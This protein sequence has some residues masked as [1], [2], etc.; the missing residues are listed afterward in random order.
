MR[1]NRILVWNIRGINSQ[2]KWDALRSKINE[3]ACHIICLQ[4]TKREQFDFFYLKN[5][6]PRNFDGFFYSPSI[7]ASGGLLTI[8]NSRM[9]SA[10][11][12]QS[13]SYAITAKFTSVLDNK[14]F[15]LTNIY[16]PSNHSENFA[17]VTWLLNLDITTFDEWLLAGDF[18]LYSS[19]DDRNKT[20]GNYGEMQMFN[21]LITDLNLFD[22]PFSGVKYTWSNMQLDPLLIKLD[23]VLSSDTWNLTFPATTVQP[24]SRPIS[25]H[26][27]FVINIGTKIPK[28]ACFRFENYWIEH[29]DFLKTVELHWNSTLFYANAA[30]CLSQK[31]KQ[32]RMGLKAWSKSFSNITKLLHNSNWVLLLLDGLEEQRPLSRLESTLRTLVKKHIENLLEQKRIFWRQRSTFRWVKFGDENI[33]FFQALATH[34]HKKNFIVSLTTPEGFLITDHEQKAGLL[35]E[36]YKNRLGVCEFLGIPYNLAGLF[37]QLDL[38]C[39]VTDFS[40]QEILQ[41]IKELPNSHAPGPDGFN[42]LFI[43]KTWPI[44]KS[45]FLRVFHNF[46]SNQMDISSINTCH[47]VLIPKRDNPASVDD[48]RPISL[49]NYSLKS[50]TKILS[51]RLQAVMPKLVH[52]NQYGFLKGRTIQD[53]LAWAFQ[54]LHLCHQSKKQIVMFKIDFEKAFDKMEH[55]FILD[56]LKH[57]W[58]KWISSIFKTATSSILL[59]GI[60][61]K[62]FKCKRGVRQGDPLSPLLFVLAAD[63]LHTIANKAWQL[64]VLKHPL[65]ENFGGDFPLIQYA[66]DTLVILP[67]DARILFNFKGL[68]RSF[69]DSSGLH[70]NF[71]KTFLVPINVNP[72]KTQHLAN[73][74]CCKVESMSFT[75]LGLPL[76]TT[77]PSFQDFSPLLCRIERKISGFSKMLSYQGRLILVNSVLTALPTF[78]MCSLQISPETIKQIDRYRKHCIW[79]GGDIHR[80]GTCQW[81]GKLPA[82]PKMKED[83]EL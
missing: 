61:G 48:Y 21:D 41:V 52:E 13:N 38:E 82:D 68:L 36:A 55:P 26:I 17:F 19:P 5:F 34:G 67:A 79:S 62:Q 40:E 6:C 29:K 81:P 18:N 31:L 47:I 75:Y 44:I 4:E 1:N 60:P 80:K 25:D 43:K 45:D 69:S 12:V 83:W 71:S 32:V 65:C 3:S 54:F 59:N 2:E 37:D 22:I 64:G 49:L 10:S 51:V 53:C 50:I 30:T 33:S 58:I 74:F 46:C 66:D 7:G 24:L 76:G 35:F 23:W 73:T 42:G 70:V 27:P 11:L 57:E 14:S 63:F 39:L 16:G 9:F 28:A 20:G 56:I 8:W 15:H 77:T 78:Y 72:E